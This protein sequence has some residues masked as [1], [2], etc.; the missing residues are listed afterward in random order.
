MDIGIIK[1]CFLIMTCQKDKLKH[2]YLN[3]NIWPK[4]HAAPEPT[5]IMWNNLGIGYREKELRKFIVSILSIFVMIVGFALISYGN[6]LINGRQDTES[7]DINEC[8]TLVDIT[9]Q[10]A[11]DDFKDELSS[12]TILGCYCYQKFKSVESLTNVEDIEKTL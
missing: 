5:L 1:R 8:S 3:G 4:V 10:M 9:E 11:T 7:F 12:K 2:K 6:K